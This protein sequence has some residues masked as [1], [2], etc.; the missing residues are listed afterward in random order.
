MHGCMASVCSGVPN[1]LVTLDAKG[2][3]SPSEDCGA[4]S[5]YKYIEVHF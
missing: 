4:C 2:F 5:N 3:L 1:I